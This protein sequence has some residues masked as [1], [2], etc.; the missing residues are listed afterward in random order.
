MTTAIVTITDKVDGEFI[1]TLTVSE[2]V[3]DVS[4]ATVA[5]LKAD[6]KSLADHLGVTIETFH[7]EDCEF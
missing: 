6:A 3:Y 7:N 4:G 5:D 1:G 2:G